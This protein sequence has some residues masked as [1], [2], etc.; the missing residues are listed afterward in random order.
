MKQILWAA[1]GFTTDL[2]EELRRQNIVPLSKQDDVYLIDAKQTRFTWT[3]AIATHVEILRFESVAKA[4]ALLRARGKLW[5]Q[6]PLANFRRSELIASELLQPKFKK[7]RFLEPVPKGPLGVFCVTG[8][9][10]MWVSPNLQPPV[11]VGAWEF[12]ED[13]EAPS[14]AYLKLWEIFTR[15]GWAP[16]KG[17]RCLELG[18]APGGWTWVLDRLGCEVIAVDKGEMDPRVLA[19]KRV[20]WLRQDAFAPDL[21]QVGPV[22]WF[23]SDLICYPPRLL[24]L[25]K[26]WADRGLARRFVCTLKFQGETDFAA[27]DEF[28]RLPGSKALHLHHNKHEVTWI[29]LKDS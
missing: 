26:D 28:L 21:G 22:D 8:E 27:L 24:E 17:E 6:A 5:S 7:R 11:P 9:N 14:R 1:K 20:R 10:E 13:R 2:D 15:E 19:S 18:S 16:R 4:Q 3:E 12:E 25:V 29:W 23:F